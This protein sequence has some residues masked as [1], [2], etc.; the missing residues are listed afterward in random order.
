LRA[1]SEDEVRGLIRAS[2]VSPLNAERLKK[3]LE[4]LG[5]AVERERRLGMGRLLLRLRDPQVNEPYEVLVDNRWKVLNVNFCIDIPHTL[6]LP[7]THHSSKR[8]KKHIR[9]RAP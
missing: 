9:F 1:L 7:E 3:F 2:G 5:V 4:T 8:K 6:Y